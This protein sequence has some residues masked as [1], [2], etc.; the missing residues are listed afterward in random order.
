MFTENLINKS[1]LYIIDVNLMYNM[2]LEVWV[3][4]YRI[5]PLFC[6]AWFWLASPEI[7]IKMSQLKTSLR[8]HCHHLSVSGLSA[9]ATLHQQGEPY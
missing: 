4:L 9:E 2:Q 8:S 7:W 1:A 3:N 6:L 5:N